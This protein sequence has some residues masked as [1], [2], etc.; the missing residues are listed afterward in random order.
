ELAPLGLELRGARICVVIVVQ[1]LAHDPEAERDDVV[2]VVL[3]V[4]VAVTDRVAES[5][6]D[7]A[8]DRDPDRHCD[9]YEQAYAQAEE[10]QVESKHQQQAREPVLRVDVPLDPVIGRTLAILLERLPVP[11]GLAVEEDPGEH[12]S[13]EHTSELQSR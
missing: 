10:D 9:P 6:D 11:G 7:I 5:V 3:R 4:E 13:E 1:L 8:E 12:R 2:A